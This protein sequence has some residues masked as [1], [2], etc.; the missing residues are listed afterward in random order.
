MV[1]N[2]I[3]AYPARYQFQSGAPCGGSST[4][5]DTCIQMIAEYY[6]DKTYSLAYIRKVAQAKTNFNEGS[7]TGINYLEVQNALIALGI[8][9]YRVGWDV[10]AAFVAQK[11][12]VGPVIVGVWYGSY[13]RWKGHCG[14]RPLSESGGKT[15]C[16]FNGSH[17]VLAVGKVAH[18]VNKGHYIHTDIIARDPDHHSTGRS[19]HPPYDRYS[20]A[21]LDAAMRAL[22]RNSAFSRTYCIYPTKRK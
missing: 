15:D 16:N 19:E 4:C 21:L 7:C 9:H 12:A 10:N 5:T 13:P 20:L 1:S 18:T 2:N 6:K 17:A 3:L 8:T 22:P 11:V 14:S